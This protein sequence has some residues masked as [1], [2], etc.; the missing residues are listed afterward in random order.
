MNDSKIGCVRA[1]SRCFVVV[2]VFVSISGFVYICCSFVVGYEFLAEVASAVATAIPFIIELNGFYALTLV[3]CGQMP[4]ALILLLLLVNA[5]DEL[6][7]PRHAH[8]NKYVSIYN[9]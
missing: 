7:T 4:N 2:R 6:N 8:T 5:A 1:V 3:L 9:N